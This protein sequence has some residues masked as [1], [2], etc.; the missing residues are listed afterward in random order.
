MSANNGTTWTVVGTNSS[1]FT[2]TQTQ[3]GQILRVQLAFTDGAGNSENVISDPTSIVGDLFT[4]TAAS[5]LFSGTNGDD[6]ALGLG[7]NDNLI[8]S[9]G[10][11]T[12]IGGNGDDSHFGGV[13]ND[14]M[15][16]GLGNDTYGVDSALDVIVEAAAAGIDTVNSSIDHTLAVNVEHLNLNGTAL[17]GTGNAQANAITGNAFDNTLN[18]LADNDTLG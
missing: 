6:Q 7:G 11:D 9:L 13:G 8:G 3:V 1:S 16:G 4:G 12:L 2:P 10:D 14:S 17:N 5:N 18:G 15:V